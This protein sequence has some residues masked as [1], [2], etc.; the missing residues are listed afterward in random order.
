MF[1]T[2]PVEAKIFLP[3]LLSP[4]TDELGLNQHAVAAIAKNRLDFSYPVGRMAYF[5]DRD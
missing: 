3:L 2:E 5:R 4:D 1:R